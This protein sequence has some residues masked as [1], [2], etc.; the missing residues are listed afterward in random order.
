M[1][2]ALP[3][4]IRS[5]CSQELKD[6]VT[7]F[8]RAK[9]KKGERYWNE[10]LVVT[11]AVEAYIGFDPNSTSAGKEGRKKIAEKLSPSPKTR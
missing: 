9:K 1:D 5:R 7:A 2:E 6:A 3:C 4:S 11:L 8:V 10:S